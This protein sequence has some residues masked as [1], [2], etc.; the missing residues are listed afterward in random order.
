MGVLNT[1]SL[2][3]A[4]KLLIRSVVLGKETTSRPIAQT[5][6]RAQKETHIN[7]VIQSLAKEQSQYDG[8]EIAFSTNGAWITA[9]TC[10]KKKKSQNCKTP[11]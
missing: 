5:R 10:K 4:L 3:T 11:M 2:R 7:I 1:A 8:P 9:F 6:E